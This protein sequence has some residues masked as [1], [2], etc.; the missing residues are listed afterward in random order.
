MREGPLPEPTEKEQGKLRPLLT[1]TLAGKRI[2][3]IS[4]GI[5]KLVPYHRG[6]VFLEWFKKGVRADGWFGD[7]GVRFEDIID[8]SAGHEVTAG[9]VDE[10]I[11]FISETLAESEDGERRGS[12]RESKI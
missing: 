4:G 2:L 12:V 6:E 10:A 8:Q 3:N 11:R 9:M 5:D 1:K 7:G